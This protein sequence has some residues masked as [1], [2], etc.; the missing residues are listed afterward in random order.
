MLGSARWGENMRFGRLSEHEIP[1]AKVQLLSLPGK[2]VQWLLE[3]GIFGRG[4]SDHSGQSVDLPHIFWGCVLAM[5]GIL[6]DGM[7]EPLQDAR[8]A[9]K[10]GPP[11]H[12]DC[13][14]RFVTRAEPHKCRFCRNVTVQV[15]G[16]K[17]GLPDGGPHL[18][19]MCESILKH[20]GS[21]G[22]G[23]WR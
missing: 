19:T 15:F 4:R 2:L 9:C 22:L 18:P 1:T 8:G 14:G 7:A 5:V 12:R 16:H 11:P 6:E 10:M 13:C 23:R 21:K 17:R 20:P 3:C